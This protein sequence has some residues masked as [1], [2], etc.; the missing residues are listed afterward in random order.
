MTVNSTI[1]KSMYA[2]PTMHFVS[3]TLQ[4]V[5]KIQLVYQTQYILYQTQYIVSVAERAHLCHNQRGVGWETR[6]RDTTAGETI[7]LEHRRGNLHYG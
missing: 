5:S 6:H 4:F 2:I 3:N 1:H 7:V